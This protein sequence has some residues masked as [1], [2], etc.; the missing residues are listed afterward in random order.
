MSVAKSV[1]P[2]RDVIGGS[3]AIAVI[4]GLVALALVLLG[5]VVSSVV[6]VGDSVGDVS[7]QKLMINDFV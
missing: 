5:S 7:K 1:V 2:L 3:E 6:V 4:D